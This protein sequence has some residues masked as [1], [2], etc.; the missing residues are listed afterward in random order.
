[1]HVRGGRGQR[2]PAAVVLIVAALLVALA[3]GPAAVTDEPVRAAGSTQ[4]DPVSPAQTDPR[5]NIV[6][7]LTD[8]QRRDSMRFMP[9]VQ[10]LL[11]AHGTRYTKAMVPTSLCCPS[12]ATILTGSYAHTNRLFGNGDVGGARLGG[13]RRFFRTGA[14]QRT[15]AVA[16][17]DAGY[18]TALIGK[19][20]NYFGVESEREIGPGYVPPGWDEFDVL[21][22]SHGSYYN[23]RLSDGSIYGYEPAAYSTDVFAARAVNFLE[24][25]PPDQPL[26]LFFAP[27]AP[28]L[29]YTPAPRHVGSLDGVLPPYTAPTLRQPLRTMPRWMRTRRHFTQAEVDRVRQ[30]QQESLLAVD[31]AVES[32]HQAMQ[33]VGRDGNTLFVYTSD[34]GYFWGEHRVIGKDAPYKDATYVPMVLRWDGRVPAGTTSG[35]LVLNVDLAETITRAAGTPMRTDGLDMLGARKRQGFVLEAMYGYNDRPAYCGWRT[36]NRM[37]VQWATGEQELFDYRLDPNERHNLAGRDGWADV[38]RRM[39]EKAQAACVPRPPG[40]RW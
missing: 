15:M 6:V 30:R 13:W 9:A 29:R 20:L 22:S 40:F 5:P 12:R 39:R 2:R 8:D 10:R 18:R 32:I 23:Y 11:V 19:Y 3:T 28:H 4:T 14:E 36:R 35:R 33:Q 37:Y 21:M 26:L 27:Y 25:T 7:I 34:N 31:E 1:M 24:T 38:Q 17:H 16:L